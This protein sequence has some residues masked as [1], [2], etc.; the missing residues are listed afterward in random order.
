[1]NW[2]R[3]AVVAAAAVAAACGPRAPEPPHVAER[4]AVAM[5]SELRLSAWT[6]DERTTVAAFNRVFAEF[7]RLESLLSIWREGSDVQRLNAAAGERPVAVAADTRE[8]LKAARRASD[9]TGGKFD[10]TFGAL[11]DVWK[12]DHDQDDRVPAAEEIRARIPLVDYSAVQL[13]DQ[14]GTAFVA[15]R[16]MRI[17]LGGIGKGYA[18]DRGAAILRAAGVHDFLIQAGGD[19]YASGRRGDRAWRAAI[20]DP[21]ATGTTFAA[22]D[23]ANETLSTSGDYERFFI[24]DGRR[25]H[26]ILDP[27]L[28]EPARGCRSVTIVTSSALAAD[29]LSTGVFILGPEAGMA[30][31]E[32]LEGVE[33]VIVTDRNQVLVSSGLKHRLVLQRPPTDAP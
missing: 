10:I 1:V 22:M 14:A 8:V 11:A 13:D 6:T 24:R 32:H 18:V 25:Y 15:R 16:G 29:G 3:R 20:A 33:G 4:A 27:D 17:H 26:H 31:I 30:L 23:L 9:T 5:G 21:R 2:R 19:L 28:G 7:E 12:F